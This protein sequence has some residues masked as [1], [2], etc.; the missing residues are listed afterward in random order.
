M[1]TPVAVLEAMAHVTTKSL[2]SEDKGPF[3]TL[4]GSSVSHA[5]DERPVY[6]A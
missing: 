2:G 3:L 4:A 1:G 6:S 5:V